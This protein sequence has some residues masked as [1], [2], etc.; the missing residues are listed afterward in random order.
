LGAVQIPDHLKQ[1][2]D[3]QV[4]EGRAASEADFVADALRAYADHIEAENEIAA[5]A[6]RAD[7]DMESLRFL[8][9][10]GADDAAALR[11]STMSR[12]RARLSRDDQER[13]HPSER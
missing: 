4:A 9:I 12:L 3:R 11:A 13:G 5:M 7:A 8:T 10:T 1:F 2:I 6:G